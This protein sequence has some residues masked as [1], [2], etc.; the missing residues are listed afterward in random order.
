MGDEGFK[1]YKK[2]AVQYMRPYEKGE[3]MEDVSVAIGDAPEVGGMIAINLKDGTD[4]WYVS[5]DFFSA[6]YAPV[7]NET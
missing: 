2:T 1:A 5:K 4:K 6:N 7:E 3:S